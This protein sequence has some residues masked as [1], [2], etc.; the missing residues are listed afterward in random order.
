MINDIKRLFQ[1]N[2]YDT[3]KFI[4][5]YVCEPLIYKTSEGSLTGVF[6]LETR[7]VGMEIIFF[8]VQEEVFIDMFFEW[9]SQGRHNR[10]WYVV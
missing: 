9:L 4:I 6:L 7:L 1:I 10:N 2:E 8:K 5:I 3:I